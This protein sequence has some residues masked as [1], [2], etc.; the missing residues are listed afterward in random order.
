MWTRTKIICTIGPAVNTEEK[1]REL[2]AAGMNVAR[3]NFSHQSHEEHAKVI[4]LLKSIRKE[5]NIPL[6]I[7]LDTKGPEVR[8]GIIE[9]PFELKKG[10]RWQLV[11]EE[12]IGNQ[13]RA[14]ILPGYVLD[15][16]P[17]GA[18]VLLDNGYI[19][20]RVVEKTDRGVVI[21]IDNGGIISS[22]KGVNLPG[23]SLDQPIISEKDLA[24]IQFGCKHDVDIIAASFICSPEHVIAVR[25][26]LQSEGKSNILV[27]AKIE[28]QDGVNNLDAIL[29]VSDGL[30]VARGDLG[31]EVPM[32]EVPR[33]QKMM[34]RK[35]SLA[36]K[37]AVTATHMLESMITN[38]RPT[39]AETSDVANA[40]YD[41]TSAI[42]L[43]GETAIGKYPIETVQVMKGI[44]LETEKD[45]RYRDFFAQHFEIVYRDVPSAV[46]LATVKTAYSSE[47]KAI[48]T[49]TKS[50][51][52]P[53]L[54]AR[55]RPP[56][57]IIA[58]T[59][60]P[61]SYHQMAFMWGVVP[62]YCE[63]SHTF[64]DAFKRLSD[65]SIEEGHVSS[66]DLVVITAGQPFGITGTTNMMIVENIGDVLVRGFNGGGKEVHGNIVI[67]MSPEQH[68]SYTV[69]NKLIVLTRCDE[70]YLPLIIDSKGIILQNHID[71]T[72]SEEYLVSVAKD[73]N[74]PYI[75]RADGAS[76]V[77]KDG[78]LV[79]LEPRKALVYK[80]V[81]I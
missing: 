5:L 20:S 23:I 43:S 38:P 52:T 71:D 45:F 42:M 68:K 26:I 6:S 78:Q 77:L 8:L 24:D 36:G 56:M 37:P 27:I 18:T 59:P 34:I 28:N 46:T 54:L 60:D 73:L 9:E 76:L 32:A 57:P 17:M 30:M 2:I 3:L 41:S 33:L 1:I 65:Y 35:S 16:F 25:E 31:V 49:F 39:R 4:A 55:L 10:K 44:A 75:I 64:E 14:S 53:R 62:Y 61:K 74:K 21:E 47:A 48:F 63:S 81:Q 7:M 72:A 12:I 40:I 80:G 51:T 11:D 29:Q 22:N 69:R 67:V 79:T 13:E 58:M 66:G 15:K 70:T 19:S 50:G